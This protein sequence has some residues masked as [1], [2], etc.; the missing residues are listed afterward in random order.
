[1]NVSSYMTHPLD[2]MGLGDP[3]FNNYAVL[4]DGS[5]YQVAL[6]HVFAS[7]QMFGASQ[8]A[9]VSINGTRCCLKSECDEVSGSVLPFSC[10]KEQQ[11]LSS[12]TKIDDHSKIEEEKPFSEEVKPLCYAYMQKLPLETRIA[13]IKAIQEGNKTYSQI[14]QDFDITDKSAVSNYFT[15]LK[16]GLVKQ[17]KQKYTEIENPFEKIIAMIEE[18]EKLS[19]DRVENRKEKP[20]PKNTTTTTLEDYAYI[21]KKTL[22]TRIAIIKA[23]QEGNKTYSQIAQDFDIPDKSA[24]SNYFTTLKKGLVKQE[25]QKYTEIEN[26]FEKII[27]MIEEREKRSCDRAEE[28]KEKKV[29]KKHKREEKVTIKKKRPEGDVL[30]Q[31]TRCSAEETLELHREYFEYIRKK[32]QAKTISKIYELTLT[33]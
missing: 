22:E 11:L 6:Q 27:A 32:K 19:C 33:K 12:T 16:K 28:I 25:K 30:P 26:P 15:T 21:R 14:A 9:Y 3:G 5:A 13:I 17:E 20:C 23:I 7:S 18:R 4:S 8:N 29:A 24:V 1:M 10:Q 31:L 2:S